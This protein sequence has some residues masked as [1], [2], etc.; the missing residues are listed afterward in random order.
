MSTHSLGVGEPVQRYLRE[1]AG[2]P[3]VLRALREETATL[4]HA[5]MQISPEQGALMR[6]LVGMLGAKKC[7]A[8]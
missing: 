6:V 8:T 1:M 3:E 2:E 4:P 7:L 5:G